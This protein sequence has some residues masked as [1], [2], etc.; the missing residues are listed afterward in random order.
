MR[1][2]FDIH[3]HTT[4]SGHAFSTFKENLEEAAAFTGFSEGHLYRLTSGKQ[5][6]HYKKCRKLYFK[7]SELEEWMLE[8]RVSTQAEIESRAVTYTALHRMRR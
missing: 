6:P 8:R 3:T 2:Y 7:K 4:A 1:V 5:I